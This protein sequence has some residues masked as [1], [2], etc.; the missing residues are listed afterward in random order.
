MLEKP[1]ECAACQEPSCVVYKQ[2]FSQTMTQE[3]FCKNCPLL[4]QKL[5]GEKK[6]S[7]NVDQAEVTCEECGTKLH[8]IL[9]HEP[10][11]CRHCYEVFQ[12][13]ICQRLNIDKLDYKQDV[14][15]NKNST[16]TSEQLLKLSKDLQEA[17]SEENFERAAILRDEIAKLKKMKSD[18]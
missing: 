15:I 7:L 14:M 6:Q 17:V 2:L 13:A 8:D 4:K 10:L 1:L 5:K 3:V 11:G 9:S 12:E 16:P 18:N